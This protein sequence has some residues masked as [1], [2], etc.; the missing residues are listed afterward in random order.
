MNNDITNSE[1][2]VSKATYRTKNKA[3]DK[4]LNHYPDKVAVPT[5][6]P[7]QN[8][9]SLLPDG[10]AYL[11][12]GI[13]VDNLKFQDGKLFFEDPTGMMRKITEVELITNFKTK[14][15][16]A[17]ITEITF[18]NFLLVKRNSSQPEIGSISACA[19]M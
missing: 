9:L 16:I 6:Q 19:I 3:G 11:Q 15:P 1:T 10:N 5:F 8:A 12:P 4:V 7:Y 17:K 13:N 18:N 14:E 2:D